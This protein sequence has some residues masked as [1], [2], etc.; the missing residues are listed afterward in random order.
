MEEIL[1]IADSD[2]SEGEK[3]KLIRSHL[4]ENLI[5]ITQVADIL[6]TTKV[7]LNKRVQEGIIKPFIQHSRGSLFYLP[8]ILKQQEQIHIMTSKTNHKYRGLK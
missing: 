4:Q 7:T 2:L 1:T 5:T 8:D 6:N 3:D